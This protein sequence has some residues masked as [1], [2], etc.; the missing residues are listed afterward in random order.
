MT[1]VHLR[2]IRDDDSV[3][4][5]AW[6]N[7]PAVAPF[8]YTDREITAAEHARWFAAAPQD[9]RRR[10][11]VIEAEGEPVGLANLYDIERDHHRC[12][13]AY[14][15]AE[16]TTRGKGIGAYVEY[17]VLQHVFDGLG[18]NKLWCEVLADNEA[19][20]RLHQSFGFQVE[21]RL[22]D[23]IR[24]ADTFRE[25]LGLGLL[26]GDWLAARPACRERLT[27]K[28]FTLPSIE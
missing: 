15:L 6:R 20:W 19:V 14:Y 17:W 21:A 10:Y 28:G 4:L 26:R 18:F 24:K 9:R 11:W 23:H 7:S 16:P 1:Q 13:W 5:L 12:A 25:V 8:M 2:D 27:A 3:R 22:R